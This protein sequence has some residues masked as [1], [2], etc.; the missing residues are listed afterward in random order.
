MSRKHESV[1][2]RMLIVAV[3][4]QSFAPRPGGV[5]TAA[6]RNEFIINYFSFEIFVKNVIFFL[7][8]NYTNLDFIKCFVKS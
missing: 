8:S 1:Q 2:K 6:S 3:I 7:N 5:A 4:N